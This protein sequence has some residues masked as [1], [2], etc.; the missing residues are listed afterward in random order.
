M[1][2]LLQV[3]FEEAKAMKEIKKPAAK[4]TKLKIGADND[5]ASTTLKGKSNSKKQDKK[6]MGRM[7]KGC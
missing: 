6:L 5:Y 7:K 3:R 1:K 4:G 2:T